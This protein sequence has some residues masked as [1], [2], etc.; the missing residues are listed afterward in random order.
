MLPNASVASSDDYAACS[1]EDSS[2]YA[3]KLEE[4]AVVKVSSL[5]AA[6]DA[7]SPGKA[8]QLAKAESWYRNLRSQF[9]APQTAGNNDTVLFF[10]CLLADEPTDGAGNTTNAT[11]GAGQMRFSKEAIAESICKG[12]RQNA[13]SARSESKVRNSDIC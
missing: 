10:N 9:C 11:N 7:A 8:L 6:S 1:S 3:H 2:A 12:N 5:G 4:S 13:T